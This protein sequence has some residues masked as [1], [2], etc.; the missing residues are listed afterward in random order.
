M[1]SR[2]PRAFESGGLPGRERVINV[3]D[4]RPA[5]SGLSDR[6]GAECVL[7]A[8]VLLAIAGDAE[9]QRVCGW[10]PVHNLSIRDR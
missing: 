1:A 9:G 10:L 8:N 2:V 6:L 3:G 5:D 4:D 7:Q